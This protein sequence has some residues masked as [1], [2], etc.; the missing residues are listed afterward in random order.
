M[1]SYELI[2]TCFQETFL[3]SKVENYSGFKINFHAVSEFLPNLFELQYFCNQRLY[4]N[5][6]F[7]AS[8]QKYSQIFGYLEYFLVAYLKGTNLSR[9]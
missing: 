2:I 7:G 9:F 4:F 1:H 5:A 6:T 3:L 8:S